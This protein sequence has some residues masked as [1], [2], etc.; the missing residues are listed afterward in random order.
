LNGFFPPE[1]PALIL[2]SGDL[3]LLE[4]GSYVGSRGDIFS[5]KAGFVTDLASVPRFMTALAPV[6]GPIDPAAILHDTLCEDRKKAWQEGK[7]DLPRQRGGPMASAVD[8]D[9]LFRRVLIE[10]LGINPV[11]AW[12]YWTGVRWGALFSP[13]RRQDWTETFPVLLLCTLLLLPFAL[14]IG[15]PTLLVLGA[16]W[17]VQFLAGTAHRKGRTGPQGRWGRR[18]DKPAEP[19]LKAL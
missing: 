16:L 13:Y 11:A 9:G 12:I 8:T 2:R 19:R 6:S 3:R 10:D 5:L 15:L 4:D 1:I 18:L 14:I 7:L 17:P